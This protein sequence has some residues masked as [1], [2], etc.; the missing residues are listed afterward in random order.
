MDPQREQPVETMCVCRLRLPSGRHDSC[1]TYTS[2]PDEPIC[3]ECD[4][5]GHPEAENFDPTIKGAQ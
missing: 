4:M 1:S 5:S 2:G 3:E